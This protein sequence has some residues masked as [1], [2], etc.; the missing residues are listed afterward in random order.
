MAWTAI[1]PAKHASS[2]RGAFW[3]RPSA[4][5][6]RVRR[7]S[8]HSWCSARSGRRSCVTRCGI[9]STGVATAMAP[10]SIS[11]STPGPSGPIASLIR[12]ASVAPTAA[13]NTRPS[14]P[15]PRSTMHDRRR[16]RL[17]SR[18]ACRVAD[19]DDVAADVRGEK[20]VEERRDEERIE[21]PPERRRDVLRAEQ[22]V[23]A[24]HADDDHQEVEPQR[25]Q[26]PGRWT[27]C[28]RSST[29]ARDPRGRAGRTAAP[30]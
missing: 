18:R 13:T 26:E 27:R 29:G 30:C 23:P 12:A 22:K 17:R 5:V 2:A 1:A 15:I 16:Q 25:R 28:A 14:S 8:T 9:I 4:C 21:E 11:H 10:A 7:S 6:S 19:A 24:P 20:V 3:K